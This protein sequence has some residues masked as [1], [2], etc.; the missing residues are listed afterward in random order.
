MKPVSY[1]LEHVDTDLHAS[2]PL[3][4]QLPVRPA[5]IV[6][7]TNTRRVFHTRDSVAMVVSRPCYPRVI[8]SGDWT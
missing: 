2:F 4:R 7:V 8:I 3:V 1:E 6:G 5:P